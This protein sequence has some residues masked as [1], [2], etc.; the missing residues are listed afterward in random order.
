[1]KR[2]RPV[3]LFVCVH[4][5]GRSQVAAAFARRLGGDRVVVLSAGSSPVQS[6]HPVVVEAMREVGIDLSKE[7]PRALLPDEAKEA[8]AVVTMGCG[9]ACPVLPGK[10]HEDWQFPDPKGLALDA[11]R[12]IR[13]GIRSRVEALLRDLG[14]E[15]GG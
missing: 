7:R 13:D 4:N 2:R 9:D 15:A 1:M 5:A 12:L 3:V 14:V 8:D 6:V 10:R 11:V